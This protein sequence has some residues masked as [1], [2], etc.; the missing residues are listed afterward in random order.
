MIALGELNAL[1]TDAFVAQLGA[2]FEHSPWVAARVAGKRPFADL[3]AL[4]AAMSAAVLAADEATQLTLIR[5][6]PELAG[7]AAIRGELTTESRREQK[8]AGLSACTPEQFT[9]LQSLNGDYGKRFGFPFILAVKGHTPDSV[10]AQLETRVAHSPADERQVALEQ[11]CRI[12]RFR[13]AELVDEPAGT[14]IASMAAELAELTETPPGLTCTYLTPVHRATAQRI[15]DFMLAAG[16]DTHIDAVG[17]VIGVLAAEDETAGHLLTGS[18]YDTVIDAGHFDGRLGI[19]LPVVVAGR[20][21]RAGRRLPCTLEIVAF[22]EEEGVRFKSTFL[23]SRALAGHFDPALLDLTDSD[24]TTLRAA[25]AAAGLDAGAIG[26]LKRDPRTLLGFVEV[27]I[28]QGPVLLDE[29]RPVGVVT[30][31]AGCTRLGISLT[32]VAG[33]AGTV[34]M[35]LRRDAAAGAAEFVLGVEERCSTEEDLVGTVGRL[36][37]PGGAI[38]VIPGRCELTLDLRSGDDARRRAALADL[39]ERLAFIAAR[40]NLD[41]KVRRLHD[42]DSVPCSTALQNAFARSVA[43]ITRSEARSL[44]SGAGHDAMMMANLTPVG[45][46]F[47]RCGNGGISHNPG[48][49]LAPADADLAARVF[50]DFLLHFK[51]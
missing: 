7:R 35:R 18:H 30:A 43:R 41:V 12:A 38:N 46:L 33:H 17:N 9:L 8:G 19:L 6:H 31:I 29:D 4:H 23:G 37:V 28:E 39:E 22:A 2:I 49:T 15:R 10:I 48:E 13:L 11:I 44:A 50:E 32:G 25:L 47:V 40:R 3:R 14:Q 26:A 5:A 20:L 21:R 51:A 27:H 1:P 36:D 24:G 16:L 34:P 45:M 42:V